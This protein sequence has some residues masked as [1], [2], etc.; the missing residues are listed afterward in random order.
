MANQR[1]FS[2][3]VARDYGFAPNPFHGV[4]TLATCKPKIRSAANVGDYLLGN[5]G[6][7]G[8]YKLV[9]MAKVSEKMTFD[10]YWNDPRFQCKKPTIKYGN[11]N[12]PDMGDN[13]EK[14]YGDN[15]YHHSGED[16]VQADCHHSLANGKPNL[17]NLTHDTSSDYVLICNEFFYL[18][19]SMIDFPNR[20]EM[21]IHKTRGYSSNKNDV[22]E[23]ENLWAYLKELY[24]EQYPEGGKIANP[25]LFGEFDRY[26]GK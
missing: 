15:V 26:D 11:D 3:I 22:H 25:Q 9:Y 13:P 2:Y 10:S 17:E 5:A 8:D 18:G 14:F 4:L 23:A 21:L 20:F 19:N 16:W 6:K 1:V 12:K 7:A 24:K